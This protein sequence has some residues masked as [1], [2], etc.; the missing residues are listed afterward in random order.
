MQVVFVIV[1]LKISIF[2]RRNT[3]YF[4]FVSVFFDVARAV[5]HIRPLN[6]QLDQ[7]YGK[8]STNFDLNCLKSKD[9]TRN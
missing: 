9:S 2:F 8:I 3:I 5:S 6:K 1:E 4:I 7:T